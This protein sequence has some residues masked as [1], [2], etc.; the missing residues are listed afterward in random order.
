MPIIGRR[1]PAHED[2]PPAADRQYVGQQRQDAQL[3]PHFEEDVVRV[4]QA[5]ARWVTIDT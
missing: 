3:R 2:P 4:E 5:L 1:E